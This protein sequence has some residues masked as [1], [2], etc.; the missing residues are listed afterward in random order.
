MTRDGVAAMLTAQA[1]AW[2]AGDLDAIMA[3]YA[4]DAVL[5]LPG[6]R[7]IGASAIRASFAK[8]L[9]AYTVRRVN[10]TRVIV[11]EDHGALEWTWRETRHAD[12]QER[13][14]DDAIIFTLRADKITHWREYLDTATHA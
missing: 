5:I 6:S 11:E 7:V 8:Y 10:L 3:D 1:R 14:V 4:P 13:T 2:A 9:A 12:G